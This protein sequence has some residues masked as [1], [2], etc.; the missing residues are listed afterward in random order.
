MMAERK[1][2]LIYL[3][4]LLLAHIYLSS[5][6]VKYCIYA[7]CYKCLMMMM[8]MMMMIGDDDDVNVNVSS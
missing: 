1:D 5:Q 3:K 7:R 4:H 8:M 6:T 2:A